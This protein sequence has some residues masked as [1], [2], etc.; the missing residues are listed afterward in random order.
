MKKPNF[1]IIIYSLTAMVFVVLS[2]VV[3]WMFII[4]AVV[5]VWLNQKE[6]MKS[7]N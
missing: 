7:K 6:L 1:K 2:F 3:D 5:L 4:P